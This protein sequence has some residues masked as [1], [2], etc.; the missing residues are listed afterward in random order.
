MKTENVE[1]LRLQIEDHKRRLPRF[2]DEQMLKNLGPGEWTGKELL[3]HLS[4]SA[5]INRQR[6]VRSQYEAPYEFPLYEQPKWTQI[7]AYNK[8]HW[9]DLVN[10]WVAEYQHLL[11]ILDNLPDASAS[12]KCPVTFASSDYVTLDWLVGHIYRH[13]DHHLHQLY[14]LVGE[15]D[16]P[17][18]QKLSQ[19]IKD[20]P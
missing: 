7:Q 10:L 4:D 18:D 3:G 9:A 2:S 5:A 20:L 12:S 6:I 16:L 17:D 1:Q 15:S 19:P 14:W 13:N 8:Y 11:H